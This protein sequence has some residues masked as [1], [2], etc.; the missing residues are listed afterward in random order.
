LK[1]F[2]EKGIL[3]S[4]S[5]DDPGISA[6]TISHEYDVAAVA[7]GLSDEQIFQAQKNALDSAFLSKAEKEALILSKQSKKS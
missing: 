5:T 3:A 7:A 4:I 6:V 2:I 1:K